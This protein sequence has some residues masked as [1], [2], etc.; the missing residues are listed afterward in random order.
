MNSVFTQSTTEDVIT[1]LGD[2][3]KTFFMGGVDGALQDAGTN[4]SF[5]EGTC[6]S[7]IDGTAP[8]ATA[9]AAGNAF[10][11]TGADGANPINNR[12]LKEFMYPADATN[13]PSDTDTTVVVSGT[14]FGSAKTKKHNFSGVLPNSNAKNWHCKWKISADS[15]LV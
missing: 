5:K 8:C 13:C 11:A 12:F 1:C 10:C 15:G 4:P 7:N 9:C 14:G 6:C 2:T 3:T